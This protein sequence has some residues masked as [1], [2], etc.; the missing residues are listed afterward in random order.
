[1]PISVSAESR[2]QDF[3]VSSDSAIIPPHQRTFPKTGQQVWKPVHHT[4]L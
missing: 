1:M 2:K 4:P 3:S